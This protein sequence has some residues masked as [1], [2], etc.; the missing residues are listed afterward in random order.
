MSTTYD[1]DQGFVLELDQG[2]GRPEDRPFH[3]LDTPEKGLITSH[4]PTC[5]YQSDKTGDVSPSSQINFT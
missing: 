1:F 4:E 5:H 2:G 3:R